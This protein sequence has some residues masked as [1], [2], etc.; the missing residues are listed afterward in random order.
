MVETETRTRDVCPVSAV[1][2]A[3]P[4]AEQWAKNAKDTGGKNEKS[5]KE[6][7]R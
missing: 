2:K 3:T 5:P 1:K 4:S 7:K 6:S